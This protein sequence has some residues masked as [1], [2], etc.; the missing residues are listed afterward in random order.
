MIALSIFWTVVSI[1]APKNSSAYVAQ[2]GG[3][4]DL[5]DGAYVQGSVSFGGIQPDY[6]ID[7]SDENLQ[8]FIQRVQTFVNSSSRLRFLKWTGQKQ[9]AQKETIEIV[10][11]LIRKAL[12]FNEYD[13][14]PYLKLLAEHRLKDQDISLGSYLTCKAGVCRENALLTHLV[15]KAV[16]IA[17]N[18]VY[19]KIRTENSLEDHAVV[20]IQD[21]FGRW[22]VDP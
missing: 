18:Y 21:K 4:V 6:S 14:K 20:V 10:T 1:A 12:P 15:L 11:A 16:G 22:I 2:Q 7:L 17:N 9:K 19:L 3:F 13:S 8:Q 5:G